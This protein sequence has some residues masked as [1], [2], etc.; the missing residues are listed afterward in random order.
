V[1]Y[2]PAAVVDE[3]ARQFVITD[4]REK[5]YVVAA[6]EQPTRHLD[7]IAENDVGSQQIERP[8]AVAGKVVFTIGGES[9]VVR[10]DLPSLQRAS[11]SELSAPVVWGPFAAGEGALVATADGQL[12][13]I[14][15]NGEILWH[16]PVEHGDMAGE[17]LV[18]E[19]AVLLAY[20]KGVFERRALSDGMPLG[21][22][23]LEHSL[24]SGP[25]GF[26]NRFVLS[27]NDG[28]LLVVDQP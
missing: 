6:V 7:A 4:G 13:L 20:R 23:D 16:V 14:S 12:Q 11:E 21:A 18:R 17:P 1:H 15:P 28:T 26:L 8:V 22:T 3:A 5:I 9:Q 10:Y 27:A 25:V 19:D 2:L 24:A